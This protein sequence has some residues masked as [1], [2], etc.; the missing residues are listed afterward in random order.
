METPDSE[1]AIAIKFFKKDDMVIW[2]VKKVV[3]KA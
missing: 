2:F 3:K 1:K